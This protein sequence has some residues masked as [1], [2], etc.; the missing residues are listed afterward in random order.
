VDFSKKEDYDFE[1]S[2]MLGMVVYA[3]NHITGILRAGHGSVR[4]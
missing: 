2:Y 3:G 4:W 1:R